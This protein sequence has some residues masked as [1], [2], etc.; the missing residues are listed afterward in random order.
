VKRPLAALP[1]ILLVA[2]VGCG[3]ND[4]GPSEDDSDARAVALDCL[5]E[6]KG[7]DARPDGDDGI[8]LNDDENGPRI[9]FFLTSGE[10]E[11]ASFE[12]EAEGAEQIGQALLYVEPEI[13]A[14]SEELLEDVESCL[15]DL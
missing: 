5:T 8:V 2:L 4:A 12:G 7:V 6:D 10:A 13:R 1:L 3:S 9:K 14:D 15:A 11:A